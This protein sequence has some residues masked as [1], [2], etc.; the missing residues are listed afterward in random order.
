MF[1][2]SQHTFNFTLILTPCRW[3]KILGDADTQM[4]YFGCLMKDLF[5]SMYCRAEL[6]MQKVKHLA[7]LISLYNP[8][9]ANVNSH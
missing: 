2:H 6:I 8:S 7:L 1:Q 3:K 4:N 5:F 9:E